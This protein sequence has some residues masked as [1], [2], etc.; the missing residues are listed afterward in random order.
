MWNQ[1]GHE[2]EILE[3]ESRM[4]EMQ[5]VEVMGNVLLSRVTAGAGG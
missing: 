3:T 2:L 4:V 5:A 1:Q